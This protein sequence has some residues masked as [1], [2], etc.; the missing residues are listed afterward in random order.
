MVCKEL[1][2]ANKL[3]SEKVEKLLCSSNRSFSSYPPQTQAL[4]D[5]F[6]NCSAGPDAPVIIFVSKM[7]PVSVQ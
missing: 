5:V 1:P 4:K 7:F 3:S 2:S 6:L